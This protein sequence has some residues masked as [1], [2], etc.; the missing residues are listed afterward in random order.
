MKY[1]PKILA[2]ASLALLSLTSGAAFA[3][4]EAKSDAPTLASVLEASGITA[5]GYV[6]ASYYHSSGENTFH[7]F[8]TSHDTFQLDQASLTVAYQPKEGF[9]ALVDVIAGED[10]TLLST[11]HATTFAVGQAYVQYAGGPVTLMAGKF[12]TLAGAEVVAPTGNANFSRSLLFYFEPAYH[13]G[14]RA[15]IAASDMFTVTFGVNNG[16]NYDRIFSTASGTN[17]SMKT[18]ELGISFTPA[19]VFSLAAS[20]YVGKD[21]IAEGQRQLLDVVATINATDMLSFV[22]SY[23]NGQQK[24]DDGSPK[25]KWDGIAAYVNVAFSDMFRLSVR[26]EQLK[27]KNGYLTGGVQK[28]KEGTL[29]LGIAPAKSYELRLEGRRDKSDT[30]TF[31]KT[32]GTLSKNQTEFAVQALYKF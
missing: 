18:G 22:V 1:E 5:T 11:T 31:V 12:F 20:A 4:D 15:A 19:K 2:T 16:W 24:F 21:P 29:T 7:N 9:G 25:A 10:A 32:D 28:L 17:A 26:G 3:A 6:A 13:T 14:V 27:D 30:A 23:D 8:D